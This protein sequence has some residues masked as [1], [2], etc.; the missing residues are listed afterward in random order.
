MHFLCL[1][2]FHISFI[3]VA[4]V[5]EGGHLRGL[6]VEK[7]LQFNGNMHLA[8]MYFNG[9]KPPA[10]GCKRDGKTEMTIKTKR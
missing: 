9:S 10:A 4:T 7:T 1:F 8:K 3:C 5:H 2:Q 6:H